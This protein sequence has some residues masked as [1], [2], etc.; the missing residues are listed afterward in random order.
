MQ[1]V[2]VKTGQQSVKAHGI[3]LKGSMSP[4][5]YYRRIGCSC[6]IWMRSDVDNL[7]VTLG[8]FHVHLFQV[9]TIQ[10]FLQISVK[11]I[12]LLTAA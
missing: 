3:M 2:F 6:G 4:I 1:N 10:P 7:E 9:W 11:S 5:S 12:V 8:T